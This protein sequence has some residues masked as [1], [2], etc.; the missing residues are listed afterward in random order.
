MV[1]SK[2]VTH[3]QFPSKKVKVPCKI[4][5]IADTHDIDPESILKEL[6]SSSPDV[7]AIVGDIVTGKGDYQASSS[8]LPQFDNVVQLLNGCSSIAKTYFSL[9]NHEWFLM[10]DDLKQIA[11]TGVTVLDNKWI[12]TG[13]LTIG[14]LSSADATR[15]WTFRDHYNGK[16]EKQ[17]GLRQLFIQSETYAVRKAPDY[18]W[19]QEFEELDDFK[20]LLCHHPEYWALQ[21]PYLKDHH[22][23]LVLSGHAHGGQVRLGNQGLFAPGQGVLPKY[24][25]GLHQG[26]YGKMIISRGLA[27][28]S[29]VPRLFNPCELIYIDLVPRKA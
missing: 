2:I 17:R 4:A 29:W 25:S 9:G 19:L 24:T 3:Y 16:Y 18:E 1:N 15:Y 23:D 10:P 8:Y 7:I 6:N 13:N 5:L 20:I 11:K 22:I 28:T 12:K 21:E 26:K 27:N 14:G